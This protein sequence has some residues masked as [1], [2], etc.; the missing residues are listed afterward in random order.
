MRP[1]LLHERRVLLV[2]KG[3]FTGQQEIERATQAVN[4]GPDV[5]VVTALPL[6]G[7]RIVHAPEELARGGQVADG[8]LLAAFQR[9]QAEIDDLH[10]ARERDD[11][12]LR[13]DV[14]VNQSLTVD[15][16][17]TNRGLADQLT[18]FGD[19]QQTALPDQFGEGGTFDELHDDHLRVVKRLG[20][21]DGDDVRVR[22][23]RGQL[24]FALE[25]QDRVGVGDQ[26]RPDHLQDHGPLQQPMHGHVHSAHAAAT[27]HAQDGIT[28]MLPQFLGQSS[29]ARSFPFR[30]GRRLGR[31]RGTR[32]THRRHGLLTYGAVPHVRRNPRIFVGTGHLESEELELFTGRTGGHHGKVLE[33]AVRP[34][35]APRRQPVPSTRTQVSGNEVASIIV[36]L[37]PVR[38]APFLHATKRPGRHHA[39][40]RDRIRDVAPRSV[41]LPFPARHSARAAILDLTYLYH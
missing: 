32:S 7:C 11:Q 26:F 30:F 37:G 41:L 16:V 4:V 8:R 31:N 13:F 28:R 3:C 24:G 19:R 25:S 1:H 2:G 39:F 29:L 21:V 20:L 12:V 5:N 40:P 9:G 6:F 10:L 17:E 33:P 34:A 18:R 22:Q 36:V 23:A 14:A 15:V 27:Q 35:P 38:H